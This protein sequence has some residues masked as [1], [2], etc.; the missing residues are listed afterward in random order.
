VS[1]NAGETGMT[2]DTHGGEPATASRL[3]AAASAVA[4]AIAGG[5]VVAM[6][7][8]SALGQS[9]NPGLGLPGLSYANDVE[10][11]AAAANQA[12]FDA[13]D[14]VCNPGGVYDTDPE[15]GAPP[16]GSACSADHF[17]V[18]LN[19]RELVHSANELRGS[20]ASVASL[21]LDQQGLGTA[22]R[23]T[24]AEELAALGSMATDFTNSQLANLSQHFN[25]FRLA[26]AAFPSTA[27][28]RIDPNRDRL[29]AAA[30]GD[31]DTGA[32]AEEGTGETFSRWSAFLNGG[33]GYGRREPT[34]LE[35]AFDF[36]GSELTLGVDWRLDGD[37]V[38]GALLGLGEQSVDFDETASPI[39]VVDGRI[40]S[41]ASSLIVFAFRQGPRLS[42]SG[43]IGM[44]SVDY[45]I[46]RNIKYPSFNPDTESANSIANS[47]PDADITTATMSAG[48]AVSRNRFTFEPIVYLE[49]VDITVNAFNEE[50]SINL[51]SD[52]SVSKRFDLGVSKQRIESLDASLGLRFQYVFTPG[53]G[54][55]IPYLSLEAHRELEDNARTIT[56]GFAAVADIL[57]TNTF[58][59]P[60]DFPDSSYSVSSLG[61]SVILRGG[62]QREP[63][64]V[65]AGGLSAF[66]QLKAIRGLRHYDDD[67]ITGGFRYEF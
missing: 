46:T 3:P 36:D 18:Y 7:P 67:V 53:F 42:L 34:G 64:G 16:L 1:D 43:S 50:R 2:I 9:Q 62:R 14:P 31:P 22:L 20:G 66:V 41:D 45:E 47:R 5:I 54:V 11:A 57:G 65:I 48:Y 25:M 15:P 21:G 51:L 49:Y 33:F 38:V 59:V 12:T 52:S 10:V 4:I 26:T 13:L 27:Y 29:L 35:D 40:E 61:V 30:Q 28:F 56:T 63:G 58:T 60:T 6:M 39:S 44:Q 32:G 23:W 37:L 8:L 24:A 19:T 55:A 17:F